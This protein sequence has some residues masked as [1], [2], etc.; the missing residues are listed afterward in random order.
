MR[1]LCLLALGAASAFAQP[2]SVGIKGGVPFT[3]FTNAVRSGRFDYTST[4]QRYIVGPMAELRLPFGLG[5]E[6]DVLYRR[7][8]YDGSGNAI[9]VITSQSTSGNAWE[10][11]LVAKYR[12]H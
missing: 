11:P 8:H 7:F 12:F 6:F 5:V 3:D 4:T 1:S 2:F 10:F 9:D